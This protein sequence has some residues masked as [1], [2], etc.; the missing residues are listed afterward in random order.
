M[1]LACVKHAA[2]VRS[3]PGSNSQVHPSD[4]K[5]EP[6]NGS[7]R[8]MCQ[9]PIPRRIPRTEFKALFA[10]SK[11]NTTKQHPD[12]STRSI[13]TESVPYTERTEYRRP[14][15]ERS[16]PWAPPTYPF[17]AYATVKER[18]DPARPGRVGRRL[19]R[20]G[21]WG[22]QRKMATHRNFFET[23]SSN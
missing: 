4:P 10:Y 2:S 19:S 5:T 23:Q 6:T 22:C 15:P 11:R 12:I 1:R 16:K 13:K 18:S 9:S 7:Q 8:P 3:E 17:L 14:D 20:G 21:P